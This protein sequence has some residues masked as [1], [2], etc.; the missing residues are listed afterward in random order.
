[1]TVSRPNREVHGV[2]LHE[3]ELDD[4]SQA[5]TVL[6]ARDELREQGV[7]LDCH[8]TGTGRGV[9]ASVR[10]DHEFI[11]ATAG[12]SRLHPPPLET[13]LSVGLPTFVFARGPA[14]SVGTV[15]ARLLADDRVTSII[16]NASLADPTL[17]NLVSEEVKHRYHVQ[18]L[19]EDEGNV[20]L[21][22]REMP[23][24]AASFDK[25]LTGFTSA[26]YPRM[27]VVAEH[28]WRLGKLF[29]YDISFVGKT[30]YSDPALERHRTRAAQALSALS[31]SSVK[32]HLAITKTY[33]RRRYASVM[34]RS[35]I[36]LSPWGYGEVCLRDFQAMLSGA[37]L[38]KPDMS[39]VTTEPPIYRANET[40]LPCQRDFS[41][42]D[43]LVDR[44]VS[45]WKQFRE[46]RERAYELITTLRTSRNVAAL[47]AGLIFKGLALHGAGTPAGIPVSQSR[48]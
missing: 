9:A 12:H 20:G 47:L 16:R 17:N 37:V 43:D 44:V 11:L 8:A 1:M 18:L 27:D 45:Q 7:H 26:T 39:H 2:F 13:V 25:L 4:L 36:A 34:R 5:H 33:S 15:A 6:R 35:K 46:L 29:P 42:L 10:D 41:D 3:T 32:V 28:K 19:R 40:Y 24:A 38:I 30:H 22:P 31:A 14:S 21:P 48:P 23:I